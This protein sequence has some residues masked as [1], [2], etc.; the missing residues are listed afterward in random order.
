MFPLPR[1][2]H[3]AP[4]LTALALVGGVFL[5]DQARSGEI[6]LKSLNTVQNDPAAKRKYGPYAGFFGG[7]NTGQFGNVSIGGFDYSLND[8]DNSAVFGFEV[9]KTWRSKKFPVAF[10]MEFEGSF[11]QTELSG[12]L[13]PEVRA[14]PRGTAAPPASTNPL[15]APVEPAPEKKTPVLPTDSTVDAYTADM[16]AV[17]FMVNGTLSL[18]LWRYRARVGK[19][20]AGLK[21][22]IGGG[23][24]GG[25][26]WFRNSFTRSL[27]QADD[28]SSATLADATPFVIDEF[29][30]AWQWYGGIE[31]CWRDKY[32]L[33]AEYREFHFGE[34][35]DMS[36]FYT[37][38]Y[39]IGF[40]Y[41][42]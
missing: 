24:G 5:P 25:Q 42:Y 17:F 14:R 32:S 27:A 9:G 8:R 16:N 29:I 15:L 31:Y 36:D 20:V 10:S 7:A 34:L 4:L 13:D 40:R 38:G 21:P 2:S 28:P 30:S 39:A 11:M 18:D 35:E 1:F 37:K 26:V 23:F 6:E 41:R 33:F 3:S 22:Y 19:F 12:D